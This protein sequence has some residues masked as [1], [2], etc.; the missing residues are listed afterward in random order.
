MCLIGLYSHRYF[1]SREIP[2]IYYIIFPCPGFVGNIE[3]FLY[4]SD[5]ELDM[6]YGLPLKKEAWIQ[7]DFQ[8]ALRYLMSDQIQG[9]LAM[10]FSCG[11]GTSLEAERRHQMVK[12][13]ENSKVTSVTRASRNAIL[14]RYRVSR[15]Q[16]ILQRERDS[17]KSRKLKHLNARSLAVRE[18]P[19]LV[20]RPRG[21]LVWEKNVTA[22]ERSRTIHAGD[23][24]AFDEYYEQNKERLEAEALAYRQQAATLQRKQIGAFLP[25]TNREWLTWVKKHETHFREL[26]ANATKKRLWRNERLRPAAD[27]IPPLGRLGPRQVRRERA[28]WEKL[29]LQERHGFFCLRNAAGQKLVFFAAGLSGQIL[30]LELVQ[31]EQ[32]NRW[33]SLPL[34]GS[35]LQYVQPA[36]T[37]V[38]S[39]GD[40]FASDLE[41]YALEMQF[42]SMQEEAELILSIAGAKQVELKPRCSS[43]VQ[44]EADSASEVES[45]EDEG[46]LIANVEDSTSGSDAVTVVSK[47][48]GEEAIEEPVEEESDDGI[49]DPKE[50]AAPG[51]HI[52]ESDNYFSLANYGRGDAKMILRTKWAVAP[53][54]GMGFTQLSK[55][56]Q[57]ATFDDNLDAPTRSY[58]VLRAWA[59]WRSKQNNWV[60]YSPE[61][62]GWYQREHGK[63]KKAIANLG[64]A[65]GT[66]GNANADTCIREWVP[67][68]LL[69]T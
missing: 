60:Q 7:G 27:Q 69:L 30:S 25:H 21:C 10:V 17:K 35:I 42:V 68:L 16:C 46:M 64:E 31:T 48:E 2:D 38:A 12:R 14:N 18:K 45:D 3:S 23:R 32:R 52:V 19:E 28:N 65:F 56:I 40:N 49:C 6:G 29:I 34:A 57:I 26:L 5:D 67:D 39:A 24:Q 44:T 55:T 47:V 41:V 54:V 59:L 58:I 4:A 66:T 53:P 33:F 15:T 63:L 50:K 20:K 43:R 22:T 11:Q 62:A 37:L 51:T 1:K 36:T 8:Q 9:E 13:S 61:R